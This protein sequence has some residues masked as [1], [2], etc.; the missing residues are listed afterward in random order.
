M[1]I[2]DFWQSNPWEL[3]M[4]ISGYNENYRDLQELHAHMT[5]SLMNVAQQGK[6][7]KTFTARKLIGGRKGVKSGSSFGSKES[8]KE[9]V[10]GLK[11]KAKRDSTW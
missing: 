4:L 5:A 1:T 10:R 9:H 2:D 3:R 8:L 6:R 7:A 11:E